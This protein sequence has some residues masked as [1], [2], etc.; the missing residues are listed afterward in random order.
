MRLFLT[1]MECLNSTA[2]GDATL[3]N[4]VALFN[5]GVWSRAGASAMALRNVSASCVA[6]QVYQRAVLP[7]LAQATQAHTVCFRCGPRPPPHLDGFLFHKSHAPPA[8]AVLPVRTPSPLISLSSSASSVHMSVAAPPT[9]QKQTTDSCASDRATAY[10]SLLA[11]WLRELLS[12]TDR[13]VTATALL[14]FV[15]GTAIDMAGGNKVHT[16]LK[17]DS[18]TAR[19]LRTCEDATEFL[20]MCESTLRRSTTE[21]PR[22]PYHICIAVLVGAHGDPSEGSTVIF[23][24]VASASPESVGAYQQVRLREQITLFGRQLGVEATTAR[25]LTSPLTRSAADQRWLGLLQSCQLSRASLVGLVYV[26]YD[27]S[28]D[29]FD[30]SG[31]EEDGCDSFTLASVLHQN[32][33]SEAVRNDVLHPP[34]SPTQERATAPPVRHTTTPFRVPDASP[35]AQSRKGRQQQHGKR[36]P[37]LKCGAAPRAPMR[38]ADEPHVVLGVVSHRGRFADRLW[39]IKKEERHAR[40]ALSS[41]EQRARELAE[42][43]WVLSAHPPGKSIN[44]MPMRLAHNVVLV[45]RP[46]PQQPYSTPPFRLPTTAMRRSPSTIMHTPESTSLDCTVRRT[47]P[48]LTQQ[49]S[50]SRTASAKPLTTWRIVPLSRCGTTGTVPQHRGNRQAHSASLRAVVHRHSISDLER[51]C[52]SASTPISPSPDFPHVRTCAS[53]RQLSAVEVAL[54]ARARLAS[55]RGAPSNSLPRGKTER[56]YPLVHAFHMEMNEQDALMAEELMMRSRLEHKE[57]NCRKALSGA[58]VKSVHRGFAPWLSETGA[59][60]PQASL[61]TRARSALPCPSR[62][63]FQ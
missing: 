8:A 53:A 34:L 56:L 12:G 63:F 52:L 57:K 39:R 33:L 61:S 1:T 37:P 21:F 14:L 13:L 6:Q 3:T 48:I 60:P 17:M 46:E 7:Q 15:E 42:M 51:R 11:L 58:H 55:Q 32:A 62:I 18:G 38:Q 19:Q 59:H 50:P 29:L 26:V 30:R 10:D 4:N 31:V 43:R 54:L 44:A 41:A 5:P 49:A 20:H 47:G 35:K 27:A 22:C 24:D 45:S 28:H 25:P 23:L 40:L 36:L 2:S 16:P 9:A